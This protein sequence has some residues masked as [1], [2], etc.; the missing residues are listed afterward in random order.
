MW[1][2]G[3]SLKH[4]IRVPSCSRPPHPATPPPTN[5]LF[6]A[7]ASQRGRIL[8]RGG[9]EVLQSHCP[10]GSSNRDGGRVKKL[11]MTVRIDGVDGPRLQCFWHLNGW[12][13]FSRPV[14]SHQGSMGRPALMRS[15]RVRQRWWGQCGSSSVDEVSCS[16]SSGYATHGHNEVAKMLFLIISTVTLTLYS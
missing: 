2:P 6:V 1:W 16:D 7:A 12:V 3:S 4:S 13:V 8:W 11:G 14:V 15:Q 10:A 5:T 9:L